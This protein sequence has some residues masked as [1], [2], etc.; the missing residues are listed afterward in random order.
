M[1]NGT[2]TITNTGTGPLNGNVTE[3]AHNPP[4]SETG[5]GPFSLGPGAHEDVTIKYSPTKKGSASD[6]AV[7]TSD[8]PTH[9]KPINVKF[10]GKSK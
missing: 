9:K 7:V 10:K 2:I 6:N 3:P 8:D 5:G 1:A 4:F